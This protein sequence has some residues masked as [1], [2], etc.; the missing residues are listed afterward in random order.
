M[1]S[2][3]IPKYIASGRAFSSTCIGA[4]KVPL[5]WDPHQ[6]REISQIWNRLKRLVVD[7]AVAVALAV[8]GGLCYGMATG[9]RCGGDGLPRFL[10]SLWSQRRAASKVTVGRWR[11]IK[12]RHHVY[13]KRE[14]AND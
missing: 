6:T 7:V 11:G 5:D 9:Y 4:T 8:D 12:L 3:C 1:Y 10:S 13:Q 2:V 14:G